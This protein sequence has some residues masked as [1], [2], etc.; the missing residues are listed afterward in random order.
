[1]EAGGLVGA[2]IVAAVGGFLVLSF[3]KARRKSLAELLAFAIQA[4]ATELKLEVGEPIRLVTPT[5]TRTVFGPILKMADYEALMLGRLNALQRQELRAVGRYQWRF[6]EKGI[7]RIEAEI[8]P[9]KARL[10]LP[11]GK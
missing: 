5:D 4:K 9:D 6:E 11:L 3:V 10:I 8:E 1:M 2:I 7:G